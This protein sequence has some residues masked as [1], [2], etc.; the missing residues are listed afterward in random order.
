M[1]PNQDLSHTVQSTETRIR[2]FQP[3]I[4]SSWKKIFP[5]G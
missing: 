2:Y 5:M 3:Q 1:Q 4:L